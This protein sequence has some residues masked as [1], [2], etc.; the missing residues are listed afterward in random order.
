M[1]PA[2]SKGEQQAEAVELMI[3]QHEKIH[4]HDGHHQLN[5]EGSRPGT[6]GPSLTSPTERGKRFR[7]KKK[8][9]GIL[10][11]VGDVIGAVALKDSRWNRA[12]KY[13]SLYSARKLAR[14]LFEA[15]SDNDPPRSLV[16][17]GV[18][19]F[20]CHPIFLC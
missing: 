11:Q 17:S 14:K 10:D 12:G 1:N 15:L 16:V 13:T 4:G 19:F 3:R 20:V 5:Y 8:K 18:L 6:P 9:S 7:K 2:A